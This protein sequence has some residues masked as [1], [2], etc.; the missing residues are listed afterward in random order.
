M[1]IGID[2]SVNMERYYL[3]HKINQELFVYVEFSEKWEDTFM[4]EFCITDCA[5]HF[6]KTGALYEHRHLLI[7]MKYI[8]KTDV[9]KILGDKKIEW[10][11]IIPDDQL[12]YVVKTFKESYITYKNETNVKKK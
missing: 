9:K 5:P 6:I 8:A 2:A 4:M 3:R 7:A 12:K 11:P 10:K 1:A